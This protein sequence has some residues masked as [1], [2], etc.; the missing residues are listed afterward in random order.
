MPS[1]AVVHSAVQCGFKGDTIPLKVSNSYKLLVDSE[2]ALD[3]SFFHPST[4]QLIDNCSK[5]LYSN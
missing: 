4:I 1:T 2:K 3:I 5:Q